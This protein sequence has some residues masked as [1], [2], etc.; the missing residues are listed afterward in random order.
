MS[1]KSSSGTDDL[2]NKSSV[3]LISPVSTQESLAPELFDVTR[4][5]ADITKPSVKNL[6][7]RNTRYIAK[8][9]TRFGSDAP[10]WTIAAGRPEE[11]KPQLCPGPGEYEVPINPFDYKLKH[12][13]TQRREIDFGTITSNI[14]F[15]MPP[16]AIENSKPIHIGCL[17]G[18]NFVPKNDTPDPVY[19]PPSFGSDI[20]ITIKGRIKAPH[21]DNIPGPGFYNPIYC[22]LERSPMFAINGPSTYGKR[23][24]SAVSESTPGPG[25]YDVLPQ[26][27]P[28]R[29]WTEK[30]RV[31]SRRVNRG[32][33][34]RL[35]PW[36]KPPVKLSW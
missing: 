3:N 1:D 31:K 4:K 18:S 8:D 14:E 2:L 26:L 10:S 23:A 7:P 36:V 17:T 9:N 28:I 11:S 25:Q 35:T 5:V 33:L 34:N 12:K 20:K 30:I 32:S 29:N 21:S 6:L 24:F 16:P 13:I 22:N 19:I 15:Y 27:K